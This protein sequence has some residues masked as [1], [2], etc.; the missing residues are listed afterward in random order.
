MQFKVGDKVR[1][2]NKP[3]W[4]YGDGVIVEIN[5]NGWIKVIY[6]TDF[7]VVCN[8]ELCGIPVNTKWHRPPSLEQ[9]IVKNTQLTFEFYKV[10]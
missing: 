3:E 8:N 1:V 5:G 2:C 7:C 6:N 9:I 4:K 10:S